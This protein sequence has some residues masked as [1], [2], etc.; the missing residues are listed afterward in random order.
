MKGLEQYIEKYG[1]HFTE[2]L[3]SDITLKKWDSSKIQ[4]SAQKK[5]YYNVTGSTSGDMMYLMDMFCYYLSD[6]YTHGSCMNLMLSWVED[7][8]KT[9]K[10]FHIWLTKKIL[11]EEEFD[12]TPYI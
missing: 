9:A 5:V 8:K 10:P 6:Q 12:F 2:E 4:K 3:A 11:G 1:N 7:Y